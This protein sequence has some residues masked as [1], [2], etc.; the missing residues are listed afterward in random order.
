MTDLNSEQAP[1][2]PSIWLFL[3]AFVFSPLL[4]YYLMKMP[5]MGDS[6]N[7]FTKGLYLIIFLSGEYVLIS[8]MIDYW[9]WKKKQ[10]S[11]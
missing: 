2:K 7:K 11:R 4:F 5:T 1:K 6:F 8:S 10:K 9:K 3:L